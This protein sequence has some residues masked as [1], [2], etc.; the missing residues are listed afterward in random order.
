MDVGQFYKYLRKILSCSPNKEIDVFIRLFKK[1]K[2]KKAKALS[3]HVTQG[4]NKLGE[5]KQQIH[6]LTFHP[7]LQLNLTFHQ[8][9]V[10]YIKNVNRVQSFVILSSLADLMNHNNTNFAAML[11]FWS[12]D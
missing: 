2:L 10:H 8:T 3:K 12:H 5:T 1:L 7:I 11:L 6:L 4:V 9:L